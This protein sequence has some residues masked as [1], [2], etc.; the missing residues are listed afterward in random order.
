MLKFVSE[1]IIYNNK[2]YK[3]SKGDIE[4][5]KQENKKNP[6][7]H[8]ARDLRSLATQILDLEDTIYNI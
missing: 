2:L 6:T 5:V 4:F 3:I 1:G 7:L 8:P